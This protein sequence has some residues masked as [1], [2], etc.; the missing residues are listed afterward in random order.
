M[1][2]KDSQYFHRLVT[3]GNSLASFGLSYRILNLAGSANISTLSLPPRLSASSLATAPNEAA[4]DGGIYDRPASCS[5]E[6]WFDVGRAFAENVSP[7]PAAAGSASGKRRRVEVVN[8]REVY[9][10]RVSVGRRWRRAFMVVGNEGKR[11]GGGDGE[12]VGLNSWSRSA[13]RLNNVRRPKKGMPNRGPAR[14]APPSSRDLVPEALS[15][16]AYR[17]ARSRLLMAKDV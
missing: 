3:S 17:I 7:F 13:G 9:R 16:L 10:G 2:L 5:G 15:N 8:A 4:G 14:A 11:G 1:E 6:T 12:V